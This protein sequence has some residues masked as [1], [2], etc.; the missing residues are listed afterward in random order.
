[1]RKVCS[2]LLF[3]LFSIVLVS[4]QADKDIE[5]RIEALTVLVKDLKFDRAVFEAGEL[6]AA[7]PYA[8]DS[9]MA[10]YQTNMQAYRYDPE[11]PNSAKYLDKALKHLNVARRIEPEDYEAWQAAVS[12]WDPARVDPRPKDPEAEKVLA[13]AEDFFSAGELEK[14]AEVLKK[15]I[16]KE[17]GY[18]PAYQHLGEIFLSQKKYDEALKYSQT[19]TEKDPR[20]AAGFLLL[21]SVYGT[22]GRGEEAM[23]SLIRSLKADPSYPLAWQQ[24]MKLDLGGKK[25]EHMTRNFPKPVL[26]MI[27]REVQDPTDKDFEGVP[28]VTRPAWSTYVETKVRWRRIEFPKRNPKTKVYKYTFQEE[29]AAVTDTLVVWKEIRASNPNAS[30]VLLD[31]WL[32]ASQAS[33]LDAAVFTDMY[34]EE[35]RQ[36]FIGWKRANANKFEEYFNKFILPRAMSGGK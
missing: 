4:A 36:D 1:M 9:H 23:A 20:D 34:V 5:K 24:I 26:W 22:M 19:A 15:V 7:H 12:F 18:G 33:A 11:N 16:E 10:A 25:I 6:V 17:P 8:F 21:A 32:A 27:E 29:S 28:E 13:E 30:D 35:F 14:A 2:V 3:C 31:H